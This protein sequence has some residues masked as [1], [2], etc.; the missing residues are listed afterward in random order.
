MLNGELKREIY[1]ISLAGMFSVIN[2]Q[3]RSDFAWFE[4]ASNRTVSVSHVQV[5][6]NPLYL[7]VV[8]CNSCKMEKCGER[9]IK[10][11]KI[12]EFWGSGNL[13]DIHQNHMKNVIQA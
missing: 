4:A 12:D 5:Q 10:S 8:D 1:Y 2:H 13:Q 11:Q 7:T 3:F 9:D 6:Q